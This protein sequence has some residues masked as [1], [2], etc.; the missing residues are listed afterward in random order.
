MEKKLKTYTV[1][2]VDY[3]GT[4]IRVTGFPFSDPD[5]VREF[6]KQ[7]YLWGRDITGLEIS[8]EK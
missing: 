4:P 8:E 2:F 1:R 5:R 7:K 3:L 6:L